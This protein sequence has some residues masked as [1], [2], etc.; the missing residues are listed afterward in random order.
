MIC[1]QML[2]SICL[3]KCYAYNSDVSN[4]LDNILDFCSVPHCI[5]REFNAVNLMQ[6]YHLL[7]IRSPLEMLYGKENRFSK[8][9]A[10]DKKKIA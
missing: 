7:E 5:S 2:R 8:I 3:F 10:R 4:W 9:N 6:G 1:E